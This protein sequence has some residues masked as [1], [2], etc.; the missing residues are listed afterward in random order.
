MKATNRT[1]AALLLAATSLPLCAMAVDVAGTGGG[2]AARLDPAVNPAAAPRVEPPV[3][4][5][6]QPP[7]P[8]GQGAVDAVRP[9]PVE[10][11]DFVTNPEIVR[12]AL[13]P[14]CEAGHAVG[15][16]MVSHA[17][18]ID[19]AGRTWQR[20]DLMFSLRAPTGIPGFDSIEEMSAARV[21]ATFVRGGR[22][23][24]ECT[25]ALDPYSRV[26]RFDAAVESVDRAVKPIHGECS[27]DVTQRE[28]P[29]GVPPMM[30][31]DAVMITAFTKGMGKVDLAHSVTV[32]YWPED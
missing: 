6:P 21:V 7:H 14:C 3:R 20:L 29:A 8:L 18:N 9:A 1:R 24:A 25:L 12:V 15:G 30:K 2:S 32:D 11:P 31:G 26:A 17:S 13:A 5:W 27:A 10:P 19:T 22:P 28:P 4:P 23:Y 16:G